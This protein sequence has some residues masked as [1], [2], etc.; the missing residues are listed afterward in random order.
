MSPRRRRVVVL[1]LVLLLVVGIAVAVRTRSGGGP[2][3][4]AP[5][6][7]PGPVLLVPGYGGGTGGLE[8]LAAALRAS[9]RDAQVVPSIGDGRGD[10]TEQAASLAA[11]ATARIAAGAPSVDVVGYSAGGVV[12]R[13]FVDRFGGAAITRRV[14]TLGSPHAGTDVARFGAA[15]APGQCPTACRQLV[16]D[17][18]LLAGLPPASPGPR[19]VSVWTAD[20]EVVV[21][22][23]SGRLEGALDVQLQQVCPGVR[24]GHGGLPTDPLVQ[25][26]V[27]QALGGPGLDAV[28]PPDRCA[29]LRAAAVP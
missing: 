13:I 25:N 11:A 23:S 9:G 21:P 28:P 22:P 14:V 4:A 27:L 12:A 17:S 20:D 6:D 15:L 24:V 10:L 5:Q 7:R 2:A 29:T 1:A 18:E 8:R 16:P 19:W 26:L 3:V